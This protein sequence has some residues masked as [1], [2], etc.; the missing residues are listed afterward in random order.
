LPITTKFTELI[1]IAMDKEL[2]DRYVLA[3]MKDDPKQVP[4]MK[5]VNNA[6]I[7]RVLD[8]EVRKQFADPL[9]PAV[10]LVTNAIDAKPEGWEGRYVV[11]IRAKGGDDGFTRGGANCTTQVT[12]AASPDE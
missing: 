5:V 11:D 8:E 12:G 1:S 10:E 6:Y 9:R 2:L 7:S 3:V 4:R